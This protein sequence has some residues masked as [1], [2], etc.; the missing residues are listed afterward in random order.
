MGTNQEGFCLSCIIEM[1]QLITERGHFQIDDIVTN[2][3]G[4][5]IGALI[6]RMY[7]S[8]MLK[9]RQFYA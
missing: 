4:T 6:F 8:I 1:I 2:T 7:S 9:C 3:L 5:L